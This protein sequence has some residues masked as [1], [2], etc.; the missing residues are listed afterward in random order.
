MVFLLHFSAAM[1]R[2]TV[3]LHVPSRSTPGIVEAFRTLMRTT[4][5]EPG[6][7]DCQVWTRTSE[8]DGRTRTQV[9]YEERWAAER[10]IEHRVRSQ[11][12]TMV[13]E[14]LEAATEPPHVEF[15]FVSRQQGLDY[16]EAVRSENT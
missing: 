7:M 16:V 8:E 12:F 14:V 10:D 2:L 11:A 1:V 4:R 15:D 5:L 9:H 6:C 13:L 3:V